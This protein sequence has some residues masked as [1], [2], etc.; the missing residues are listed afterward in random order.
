MRGTRQE[1]AALGRLK[2]LPGELFHRRPVLNVHYAGMLLLSGE[3][4]G[5]EARL[6]DAEQWLDTT[7]DL[8]ER[9]AASSAEMVVVDEEEFRSLPDTIALYRAASALAV[10]DVSDT[11]NYAQ[12]VLDLV[13]A[14]DDLR[15]GAAAG[16]LGLAYWTIGDLEA[17]YRSH[18]DSMARVRKAGHITDAS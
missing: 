5:V 6:R 11:V 14:D 4:G 12:R 16:L 9:S 8:G 7:A 10:G 17:A 3:L 1:A 18:A 13:P 2:A 15:R